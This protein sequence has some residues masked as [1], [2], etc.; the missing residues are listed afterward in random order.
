MEK[1]FMPPFNDL[2]EL[3]DHQLKGLRWTVAHA[4][5][6]SSFYKKRLDESG[7]TPADVTVIQIHLRKYH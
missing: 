2:E 3:K 6:G 4:Y 5:N 7:V 1:T